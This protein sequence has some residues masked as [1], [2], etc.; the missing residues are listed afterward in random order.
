MNFCFLLSIPQ[1][2]EIS[3]QCYKIKVM[4]KTNF[5]F[6][7]R[8]LLA[9]FIYVYLYIWWIALLKKKSMFCAVKWKLWNS[10]SAF[11]YS[12]WP[13][14]STNGKEIPDLTPTFTFKRH[15]HLLQSET[16]FTD[17]DVNCDVIISC[18][19]GYFLLRQFI[20]KYLNI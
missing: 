17:C 1:E 15:F 7:G 16:W 3:F 10:R 5:F 19:F 18:L 6:F 9:L 2:A 20:F 12:F 4:A 8:V 14:R 13:I 11:A